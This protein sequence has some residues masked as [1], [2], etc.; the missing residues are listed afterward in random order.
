MARYI[1]KRLGLMVLTLWII[2]TI[3]FI[4]M[5]AV[6]GDPLSS[7][8]REL[9]AQIKANYYSKYS[10]DKPLV[11]QYFAYLSNVV[12]GNLGE[13]LVYPGREVKDIIRQY[14][15]ATAQ[16]GIQS[17][18]LGFLIGTTLGIIAALKRN[19]WQDRI[20]MIISLLGVS[21]P[22]FIL[23]AL[24]QY[25]FSVKHMWFPSTGWEGISY[26]I[27]PTIALSF[28]AIATYAR[29][30]RA[31]S[32]DVLCQD[33][34]LTAKAKGVSRTRLIFKHVL[35]NAIIPAITILAMQIGNIMAGSFVIESIFAIP[36]LGSNFVLSVTN[37]DYTMIMGLTVFYAVI[38]ILCIMAADLLYSIADPKIKLNSDNDRRRQ[39]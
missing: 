29:F 36:G 15:P 6:P 34:I 20:I 17:I 23:A 10:L 30:M 7:M 16:L 38:Y 3:T 4:L 35:R 26:T 12:H 22:S 31:S 32:L 1:I 21:I 27:L 2:I 39:W 28:S 11:F 13:S 24:L 8:P 19:K 14:A 18:T 33:Y 9:P 5:H 25:E 37:R